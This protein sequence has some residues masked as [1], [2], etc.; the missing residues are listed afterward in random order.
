MATGRCHCGAVVYE[1]SGE[2]VHGALCHCTDCRRCA[3]APAVGWTAFKSGQ[4][5]LLQG[6]PALYRSSA[7]AERWFGGSCGTGLYYIN[8]AILPGL[9]DIQT[10]TLDDPDAYPPQAHIQMADAIGWEAGLQGLQNSTDS[11]GPDYSAASPS[12]SLSACWRCHMSA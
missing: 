2:P 1:V 10:A 8:E 5:A 6:E 3:G 9:V 12:F 11:P 7:T 4:F